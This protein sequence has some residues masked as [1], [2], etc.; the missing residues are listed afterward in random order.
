MHS[1]Q[2]LQ[3]PLLPHLMTTMRI[4]MTNNNHNSPLI[5][6]EWEQAKLLIDSAQTIATVTHVNPDGDAIGSMLGLTLALR[7]QGKT[8]TPIVDGGCPRHFEFIPHI[9][10]IRDNVNGLSPELLI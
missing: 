2:N 7:E 3:L 10:D 1:K 9:E 5:R 4:W 6:L 8:V